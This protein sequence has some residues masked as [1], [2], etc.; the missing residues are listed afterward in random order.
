MN[1]TLSIA[2]MF[3]QVE[4]Q[5]YASILLTH[6]SAVAPKGFIKLAQA[7]FVGLW[8]PQ[9]LSMNIKISVYNS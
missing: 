5:S 8:Q 1:H 7:H 2:E 9:S 4:Q 6:S 3:P